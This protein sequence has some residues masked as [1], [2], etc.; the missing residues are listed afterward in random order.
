MKVVRLVWQEFLPQM[1]CVSSDA[2]QIPWDPFGGATWVPTQPT[3][4]R[5]CDAD[6]C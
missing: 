2:G 6:A 5:D 4:P 3:A 1:C